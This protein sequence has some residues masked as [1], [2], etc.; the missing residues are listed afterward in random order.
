VDIKEV[1]EGL[2]RPFPDEE[3]GVRILQKGTRQDDSGTRH[4]LLVA[5]Y[6]PADKVIDRL[7][8]VCP[9]WEM[10]VEHIFPR[11]PQKIVIQKRPIYVSVV[12]SLTIGEFT[13]SGG[14]DGQDV[15]G[16]ISTALKNAAAKFGLGSFLKKDPK[17]GRKVIWTEDDRLAQRIAF[18]WS[19]KDVLQYLE[20]EKKEAPSEPQRPSRKLRLTGEAKA[21]FM[22]VKDLGLDPGEVLKL[23]YEN[24]ILADER[25]NFAQL[26][27]DEIEAI[28]EHLNDWAGVPEDEDVPF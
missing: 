17:Y 2:S 9:D 3:I 12:V 14:A 16:A 28:R 27:P 6:I 11:D 4:W 25:R 21:L 19:W 26:T 10:R 22:E 18:D 13:R 7:N 20:G 15:R 23:A 8:E 24:G 1:I 5:P